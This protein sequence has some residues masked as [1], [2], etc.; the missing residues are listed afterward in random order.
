MKFYVGVTNN[1]WFFQLRDQNTKEPINFWRPTTRA[2][3]TLKPGDYFLFKLHSPKDFVVGGGIFSEFKLRTASSAWQEFG[4][5]NGTPSQTELQN[6]LAEMRSKMQMA[7]EPQFG[8][9]ALDKPFFFADSEWI[10]IYEFC[11]WKPPTQQGKTFESDSAGQRL[12]NEV[13]KRLKR[14]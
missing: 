7:D 6:R 4:I 8:C 11:D 10:P 13:N 1:D 3:R 9:I 5:R 12:W 2:F 14:A